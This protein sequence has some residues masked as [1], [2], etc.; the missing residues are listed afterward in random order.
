VFSSVVKHEFSCHFALDCRCSCCG[1][2]SL[3]GKSGAYITLSI[4]NIVVSFFL[5]LF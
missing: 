5:V 1:L 3:S 4:I 2:I